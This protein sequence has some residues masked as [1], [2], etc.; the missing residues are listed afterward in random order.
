MDLFI[1]KGGKIKY[2]GVLCG[3]DVSIFQKSENKYIYIPAKSGHAKHTIKNF[4]RGELKRFV[5]CNSIKS[6]YLEIRNKFSCRLRKRGS[7]KVPLR[8]LFRSVKFESRSMLLAIKT[9]NLDFCEIR[10]SE[11]DVGFINVAER[12]FSDSFSE[13]TMVLEEKNQN[14]IHCISVNEP[15]NCVSSAKVGCFI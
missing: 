3:F 1:C 4:I 2:E 15:T 14:N 5:R 6:N 9:E 12:I 11:V 13:K 7:K 8:R 10:D